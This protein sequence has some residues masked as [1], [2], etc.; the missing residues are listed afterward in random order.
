MSKARG[1]AVDVEVLLSLGSGAPS[2]TASRD[3]STGGKVNGAVQ[4]IRVLQMHGPAVD[5]LK[6]DLCKPVRHHDGHSIV[7]WDVTGK[8]PAED[9]EREVEQGE[10]LSQL[11]RHRLPFQASLSH[12]GGEGHLRRK[13]G[14]HPAGSAEARPG[15][16]RGRVRRR[17]P[18]AR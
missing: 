6:R 7:T 10:V 13:R 1:A 12:T 17:R 16:C 14:G 15:A 3:G 5:V 18:A 8:A 2:R 9:G 11:G 4:E